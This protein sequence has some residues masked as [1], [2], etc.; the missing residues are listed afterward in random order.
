MARNEALR[1]NASLDDATRNHLKVLGIRKLVMVLK[2]GEVKAI[3]AVDLNIQKARRQDVAFEID[4]TVWAL[5]VL[6]KGSL[7]VD[8]DTA[9]CI[10][11]EILANKRAVLLCEEAVC[12]GKQVHGRILIEA[13]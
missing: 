5:F 6:E 11:P 1:C 8:Y 10:D 12:E 3:C 4:E 2:Y 13:A 7:S 9:L